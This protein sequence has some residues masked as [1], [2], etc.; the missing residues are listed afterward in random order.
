MERPWDVR[1]SDPKIKY[2]A[3]ASEQPELH[4]MAHGSRGLRSLY[5]YTRNGS[6]TEICNWSLAQNFLRVEQG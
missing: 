5:C 3:H 6:M 4:Q 1:V 2:G